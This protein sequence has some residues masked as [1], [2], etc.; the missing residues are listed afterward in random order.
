M[1]IGFWAFDCIN[2]V[3]T[4]PWLK[5]V[6]QRYAEQDLVIIGVHSPEL[7]QEQ[8][9]QN[10]R[11]AIKRLNITYPVMLDTDFSYWNALGNGYWPA[12]YLIDRKGNLVATA[13]GELHEGIA[14]ANEFDRLEDDCQRFLRVS[15]ARRAAEQCHGLLHDVGAARQP[16]ER[17][18]QSAGRAANAPSLTTVLAYAQ[19]VVGAAED[20]DCETRTVCRSESRACL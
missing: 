15:R 14:R 8:D 7:P 13:T 3:R 4:L 5:H 2:C 19:S 9:P 12:F 17:V 6:Q 18:L 20:R 1:C 16:I 10:V 11:Q